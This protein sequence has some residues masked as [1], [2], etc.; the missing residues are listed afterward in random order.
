MNI[1]MT[2]F[3]MYVAIFLELLYES[4]PVRKS[5]IFISLCETTFGF[6]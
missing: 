6:C 3:Q 1:S 4:E 5:S 2:L